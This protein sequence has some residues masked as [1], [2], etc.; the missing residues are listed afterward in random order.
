M[1]LHRLLLKNLLLSVAVFLV[2]YGSQQPA[3]RVTS[4]VEQPAE[5]TTL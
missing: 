5:Q 4:P 2:A 3:A 1:T